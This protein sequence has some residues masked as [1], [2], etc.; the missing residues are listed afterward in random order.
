MAI[1]RWLEIFEVAAMVKNG[2]DQ[3]GDMTL[4]L[5]VFE[6]R[7]DEINWFFAYWYRFKKN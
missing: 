6:E 4:K 5:T 1:K 2:C 3:F 7:A